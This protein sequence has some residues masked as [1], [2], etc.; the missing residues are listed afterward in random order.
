MLEVLTSTASA[1]AWRCSFL[2][3]SC[4]CCRSCSSSSSHLFSKFRSTRLKGL[5]RR[6][7]STRTHVRECAAV[8][9][10]S[11]FCSSSPYVMRLFFF[12]FFFWLVVR[13][14]PPRLCRFMLNCSY[15][16]TCVVHPH[17]LQSQLQSCWSVKEKE[18]NPN[19][20]CCLNAS[21]IRVQRFGCVE[22]ML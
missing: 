12:F 15:Y 13:S 4:R 22:W 11:T 20:S 9:V 19:C 18:T 8:V 10:V 1:E 5:E 2:Y 21:S 16:E 14:T 6:R 17:F 7:R 3:G